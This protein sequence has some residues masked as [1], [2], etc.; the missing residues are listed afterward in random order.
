MKSLLTT[1]YCLLAFSLFGQGI[2]KPAELVQAEKN[3]GAAFQTVTAFDL[4]ADRA[5]LGDE[6]PQQYDLLEMRDEIVQQLH[7]EQPDQITFALPS[8]HRNQ[9]EIELVKV[10]LFT[11][12]FQVTDSQTEAPAEVDYGVHYRGVIKGEE[13]SVA[14]L[15]V[16]EDGMMGLF[17]SNAT[18]NLVLG[19]LEGNRNEARYILYNDSDVLQQMA[20]ECGTPDDGVGYTREELQPQ[21]GTR[22]LSDC[23]RLY[24]EVDYDIFQ[25][26]GGTQGATNYVTGIANEAATLYANENINTVISEIFVWSAT[27]PYSSSSSSGMLSDFQSYRNG[28]NGDLGHLLS[29]QASGG[30]AAG[31]SGLCNSNPDNSLCFSSIG[32]T[33]AQVPTYSFTIMVVTHEFGHLFGSRHTHACVWNGNNTAIDG[34]A[35]G[36]EGSCS[37]PGF[38][39]NGGTIMSYCH[40]QSVGINFNLGFG[41]QPGNV[42]RNRV[43]N[44]SCLQACDGGGGGG[45]ACDDNEV[46]LTINLD[47]YPGE[48]TWEVLNSSGIAVASGGSYSGAGSTVT[49]D[50]CLPNGCYDFTIFDSYGDGICCA[51]GN[52]SYSLTDGSTVLASGGNFTNSETTNFC[53]GSTPPPPPPSYC[54]SQGNNSSFEW[55]QRLQFGSINNNSG[56]DGGYGDYTNLSTALTPGGTV[57]VTLVPGFSSSTYTEY[58]RLWVDYNRDGDFT[59]AGEQ[60]G[61]GSGTGTLSGTL[62]VSSSA[63]PGTTRLRVAMKY[64]AYP[65]SCEAFPYGEV[66]DYTITIGSSLPGEDN[67]TGLANASGLESND[68]SK[69]AGFRIFPNPAQDLVHLQYRATDAGAVEV[70]LLDLMGRTL[71]AF[72][73]QAATGANTFPIQTNQLPEGTYLIRLTQDGRQFVE[74]AVISR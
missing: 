6:A 56:N 52:G 53:V 55:I 63:T 39:S 67:G 5:N 21:I 72:T 4:S 50:L 42:I 37:L 73:E 19:Q 64:N 51:Y 3:K 18:G 12:D 27:S 32:S 17:S 9:L 28:V 44:A 13:T 2:L 33:Y 29:Y 1:I 54:G 34:C 69:G 14:S 7:A 74:R 30:I 60:I 49:E 48:T 10:N 40:V 68:L 31:F 38:P 61:Q 57:S 43:S 65:T 35:G 26:K 8:T 62:S 41:P 11:D 66:E 24:Y 59:D 16:F 36:T 71:Q 23:V 25:N 47:N 15:S 58:W 20:Y 22:A 70:E 45:P 46:T